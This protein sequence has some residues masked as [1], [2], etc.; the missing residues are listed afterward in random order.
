MRSV[1]LTSIKEWSKDTKY[2]G[3]ITQDIRRDRALHE[4]KR[5]QNEIEWDQFL[6]GYIAKSFQHCY[7]NHRHDRPM[8]DYESN[9]WTILTIKAVLL[10]TTMGE[11]EPSNTW[12]RRRVPTSSGAATTTPNRPRTIQPNGSARSARPTAPSTRRTL[13]NHP[14][15]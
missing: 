15:N 11:A 14:A 1:I 13:H 12:P 2:T 7:N 10:R 3:P 9:K 5:A 6:H 4:A 8:N